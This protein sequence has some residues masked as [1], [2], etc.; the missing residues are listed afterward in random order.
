MARKAYPSDGSDDEW[1]LV[2]PCH[3]RRRTG[4]EPGHDVGC[5]SAR[6]HRRCGRSG[7]CG[8]RVHRSTSHRGYPGPAY[9]PGRGQAPCGA[10]R[11]VLLPRRWVVERSNAWAA[12]CRRLARDYERLAETLAGLPFV[13]FAILMLKYF[14]ELMVQST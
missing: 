9:A 11:L 10:K 1:A 14:V 3:S 13:A 5:Q 8:P 12:R 4:P 6:G 2:A 7:L